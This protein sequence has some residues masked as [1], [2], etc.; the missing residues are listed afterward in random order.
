MLKTPSVAQSDLGVRISMEPEYSIVLPSSASPLASPLEQARRILA[1]P[2]RHTRPGQKGDI[3]LRFAE[4]AASDN[5][6]VITVRRRLSE[7]VIS[8]HF[9][10]IASLK[11]GSANSG[12]EHHETCN[13]GIWCLFERAGCVRLVLRW[14]WAGN[15]AKEVV[16][17]YQLIPS[18]NCFFGTARGE[19]AVLQYSPPSATNASGG[20]TGTCQRGTAAIYGQFPDCVMST[21]RGPHHYQ[22]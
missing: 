3:V 14:N 12:F 1:V 21:N 16:E 15:S 7:N 22:I 11:W 10:S 6:L 13:T 19:I 8:G 2:V 18:L 17:E 4:L 9:P 5:P 20:L